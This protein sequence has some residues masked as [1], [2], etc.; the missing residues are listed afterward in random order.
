[1]NTQVLFI[2]ATLILTIGFGMTYSMHS[3]ES[4]AEPMLHVRTEFEF[5]VHAPYKTVAPLFGAEAERV[6]ASDHWNPLFLHPQPARDIEGAVFQVS[7]GQHQATWVNTAFDLNLG[8]VQYVYVIPDVMAT[9]IDI[10]VTQPNAENTK[11]NVAYER[12]ALNS[13]ANE[14]VR[15]SGED[16]RNSSKAWGD[17]I[18]KY[19]A[20]RQ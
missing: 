2:S 11:V 9:L 3:H 17:D 4:S 14:H 19:L 15:E 16:D 12:T 1:M 6:W 10:H 18:A 20:K 5:T 8:H 7:R 13:A